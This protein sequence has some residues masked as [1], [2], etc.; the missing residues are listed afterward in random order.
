MSL[1]PTS[2]SSN[3]RKGL[4]ERKACVRYQTQRNQNHKAVRQHHGVT[5]G[6]QRSVSSLDEWK[7][8]VA[9]EGAEICSCVMS[10]FGHGRQATKDVV[11]EDVKISKEKRVMSAK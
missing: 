1:M 11:R 4:L 10:T 3:K 5:R 7:F 2:R 8:N 6:F 9:F